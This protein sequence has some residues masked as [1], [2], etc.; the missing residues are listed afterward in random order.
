MMTRS[1]FKKLGSSEKLYEI[2]E[3]EEFKQGPREMYRT[4]LSDRKATPGEMIFYDLMQ[5]PHKT[6]PFADL[7]ARPSLLN[8]PGTPMHVPEQKVKNTT[9]SIPRQE[10]IDKEALPKTSR[11]QRKRVQSISPV[12]K[13]V[14]KKRS[15]SYEN[16]KSNQKSLSKITKA[17]KQIRKDLTL[18]HEVSAK[19]KNADILNLKIQME[20]ELWSKKNIK[21]L[22]KKRQFKIFKLYEEEK[23]FD[24]ALLYLDLMFQQSRPQLSKA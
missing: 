18:D 20:E 17:V 23:V 16:P 3:S 24:D 1:L 19:M 14:C 13:V 11:I 6:T 12:K 4:E 10:K 2:K 15:L 22:E 7:E 21:V 9:S 8:R 5:T